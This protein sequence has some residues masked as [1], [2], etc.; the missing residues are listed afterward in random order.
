M[1]VLGDQL[2]APE[3]GWRRY[4]DTHVGLKYTGTWT[5]P[6]PSNTVYYGGSIRVTSRAVDNNYVKFSFSE[7]SL[8]LSLTFTQIGIL[9][10]LSR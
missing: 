9:I 3:S 6:S 8:G 10:T 5:I 2:V 4:D 1:A 7:Q